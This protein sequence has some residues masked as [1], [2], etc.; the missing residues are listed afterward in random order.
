MI[1]VSIMYPNGKDVEFDAAYY[2]NNHLPM[3]SKAVG[4]ALKG[5]EL[6]L[7][8][9]SR[10]PGEP[11]PYIA[12]AH[13]NFEDVASFQAAFGPHAETFAAD[14]KNFTN[15]QGQMQISEVITF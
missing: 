3:V 8:I 5:L 12:I 11:A 7:G 4:N 1:K 9:G 2:K 6:D 14:V 13:L 10:V 15:V